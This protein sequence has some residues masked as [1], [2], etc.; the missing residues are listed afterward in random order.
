MYPAFTRMSDEQ[1]FALMR[2]LLRHGQKFSPNEDD[3]PQLVRH[4]LDVQAAV[5]VRIKAC[6]D[7]LEGRGCWDT[8]DLLAGPSAQFV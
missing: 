4:K 2:N 7:E 5:W 3:P 6:R 1:V 8:D